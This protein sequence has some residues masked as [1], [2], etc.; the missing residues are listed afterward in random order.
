ME[1]IIDYDADI[2][3]LSETW[4]LSNKNSITSMIKEYGYHTHHAKRQNRSKI[5]G[6]GV[7]IL[8]K[9][10]LDTTRK[11]SKQFLSFESSVVRLKTT[12][13]KTV[14]L[15]C[16]Y[17]V[18]F[19]AVTTFLDEI[20]EL[21]SELVVTIGSFVI[22]G[23]INIHCDDKTDSSCKR[24]DE[25]LSMFNLKQFVDVPTQTFGHTLDVVIANTEDIIISD[26]NVQDVSISDHFLV[27]FSIECRVRKSYTKTITYRK[28]KSVNQDE[29]NRNVSESF[30]NDFIISNNFDFK[31]SIDYYNTTMKNLLDKHAP[32][33]TKIIKVVPSAPWFDGEYKDL[34]KLRRKAERKYRRT[35]LIADKNIFVSLRSETT[36]LA[37]QKKREYITGEIDKNKG[38]YK[39][40]YSTVN[41]LLD[42]KQDVILPS[43]SSDMELA[44]NFEAYFRDKI[45]LIRESFVPVET[46]SVNHNSTVRKFHTFEPVTTDE[47][48]NIISEYGIKCS[49][50]D[51]MHVELLK[52]NVDLFLPIWKELVNLSLSTG[53]FD[54][55]KS[56]VLNPL[57]K[58]M[59]DQL[60]DKENYKNYR[61]VSNLVFLSKLIERCVAI[62]LD[63]HMCDN[64]LH[65]NKN[66]GY[67][68]HHSSETLLL[69]EVNDLLLSFD[70]K[71]ATVLM[72]LDLSAAFD[73]VDQEKL[74][75]I[76]EEEI[77]ICGTV[78]K[79]FI[80]FLTGRTQRVKVNK[81]FSEGILLLYGVAQ[82]SVLGPILFKIY[83]RSL[84]DIISSTEFDVEGYA[85]DHQLLRQFSP[86]LQ[87][88]VLSDSINEC[89]KKIE[90]WMNEF[91]LR[92]NASKTK[93]MVFAP[94]AISK[95]IHI[96]GTFINDKCI[97]F[98]DVAKNL[99]VWFDS[100]LTFEYQTSKVVSS[101]YESLRNIYKIK[102]FIGYEQLRTLVSSLVFSKLDYCNSLYCGLNLKEIKKLELVQN[103][104]VRLV[105]GKS[106]FDRS[107][108]TDLY[109]SAHWLRIK[110]R[111]LFK[112]CLIVHKCIWTDAPRS[113]K[114]MINQASERTKLLVEIKVHT[115]YGD[116]AFARAGPKMWNCLPK[117]IR[118]ENETCSFKKKLKSFLMTESTNFHNRLNI[119]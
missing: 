36:L 97:R 72:L 78:L 26:V 12:D 34:R 73:T 109:M 7:G 108:L 53:S 86:F 47:L 39:H 75:I 29:F 98:V 57:F 40:L 50:E 117:D 27:S 51:P 76:L 43:C 84:Y 31:Q 2:S 63:K 114:H 111:I 67:K 101:C 104:A 30:D 116:R 18:L 115:S 105:F 24:F 22:A 56:A 118:E 55:L 52:K 71:R 107:S 95:L 65:S 42:I 8:V 21:L 106:K 61:P 110:E 25:I 28:I 17:R 45:T 32:E 112:I 102:H 99:G 94:P 49:P 90:S 89:L 60:A 9:S 96:H 92:L 48:K 13:R 100:S 4:L 44:S 41:K 11:V 93:I 6:G 103:T 59:D 35:G 79:W 20:T 33:V 82:G 66:H 83:I 91:F 81:S 69:K 119:I 1:H 88:S 58:M 10:S 3:F 19:E 5:T 68:K 38:N 80:S 14:T 85:D 23:D 77:G 54:N 87:V 113:L 70:N 62:Q 46:K 74:I 37:S 15:V 16:I 64:D